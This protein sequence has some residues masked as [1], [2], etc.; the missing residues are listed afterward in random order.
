MIST[1]RSPTTRKR[2][3]SIRR[4][5][6]PTRAQAA[7]WT[8][9]DDF[10][11]AIAAYRPRRRRRSEARRDLCLARR[12]PT[13]RKATARRA[14]ADIG[15]A[16]QAVRRK[17][18]SS[19]LRGTLRLKDGDTDGVLHDADAILKLNAGSAGGL[20]AA[21]RGL[22][23][24]EAIR[25]R[26]HRSRPGDQGA[27]PRTRWPMPSAAKV[28]L[29][30]SDSDRALADL[31]RAIA[32]GASDAALYRARA[33]DLPGQGR[34]RSRPRRPQCGADAHAGRRREPGRARADQAGARARPPPPWPISRPC[35]SAIR[36]T[37]PRSAPAPRR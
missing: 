20:G 35:S 26:A 36:A 22:R 27:M 30:K 28:Y 9:K 12:M 5:S 19:N 24:Q 34:Y 18:T 4:T 17:P 10:D 15:R 31:N 7:I 33:V 21:R 2:R 16:H 14:L 3:G 29:A 13:T 25:P 23:P 6:P 37:S 11:K 32:L 8:M 1:A